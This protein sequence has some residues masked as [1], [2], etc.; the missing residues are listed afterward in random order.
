MQSIYSVS[1]WAQNNNYIIND[2]VYYNG[3]YYYCIIPHNSSLVFTDLYWGGIINYNGVNRPEFIWRP[4]YNTE[5]PIKPRVKNIQL[6]DGYRQI[7]DDGISNILL[8]LNLTFDLRA[9]SEAR[10]ILHFLNN[11]RGSRSFIFNPP[12]PYNQNK[13]F[14]CQDFSSSYVFSDNFTIRA[15]FEE[16]VV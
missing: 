13:I 2:I 9:E 7:S 6:G 11:M 5:V 1:N 15:V 4:S 16:V 3:E 14:I 12:P 8:T 10:A